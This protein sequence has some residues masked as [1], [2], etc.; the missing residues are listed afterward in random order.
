MYDHI[1]QSKGGVKGGDSS[2]DGDDLDD[3][4]IESNNPVKSKPKSSNNTT[5]SG[6]DD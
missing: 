5:Q 3:V 4:S 2:D 6:K 1:K